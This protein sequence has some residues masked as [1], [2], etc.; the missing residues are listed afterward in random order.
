MGP[1]PRGVIH[2]RACC[3]NWN[4]DLDGPAGYSMPHI[5]ARARREERARIVAWFRSNAADIDALRAQQ[6]TMGARFDGWQKSA[7]LEQIA[8]AIERGDHA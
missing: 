1:E 5:E 7:R 6:T 8:D 3:P 4:G 2:S